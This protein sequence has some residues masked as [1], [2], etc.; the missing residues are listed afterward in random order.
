MHLFSSLSLGPNNDAIRAVQ[1]W[2]SRGAG[3]LCSFMLPTS[4]SAM[5]PSALQASSA[6]SDH[7]KNMSLPALIGC[8]ADLLDLRSERN[9]L[10]RYKS[11]DRFIYEVC[12]LIRR[13]YLDVLK[14]VAPSSYLNVQRHADWSGAPGLPARKKH[15]S[16]QLSSLAHLTLSYLTQQLESGSIG[17]SRSVTVAH[18]GLLLVLEGLLATSALP[19][20]SDEYVD[21][22]FISCECVM[23]EWF[24]CTFTLTHTVRMRF[25]WH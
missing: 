17:A 7:R 10:R 23:M 15:N 4:V 18:F 16:Q 3:T 19:R 12:V 21:A 8:L 20:L 14:K 9:A 22:Y 5:S 2:H 24:V 6:L 11:L 13:M 1:V 25:Q